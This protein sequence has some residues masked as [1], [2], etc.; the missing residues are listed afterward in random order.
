MNNDILT[1]LNE[2]RIFHALSP[3]DQRIMGD[4]LRPKS[5]SP[6]EI[7]FVQGD[8]GHGM[9]II[10][11]GKIKIC[12]NDRQG[13][14]LV[15]TFLSAGDLLGEIAILDGRP[16]SATAVAVTRTNTLYIDRGEFLEFLRSS[17]S[18]CIDI[19]AMLCKTL[20]RVSTHLEE[21]SFLDVAGRVAR[22]LIEMSSSQGISMSC[23]ISQEELAKVVGASRVMVNKILQS[24]TD[25]GII[26]LARKKITILNR[27]ELKRIGS[28]DLDE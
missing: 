27:Y 18:A 22:N 13:N 15:F 17:P 10:R 8:E 25:L 24:F 12:V 20:R 28:Y 11:S 3:Q 7:I 16:R 5:F 4:L 14:E 19:I 2:I 23:E 6:N 21:V 9:Y 1:A 26:T